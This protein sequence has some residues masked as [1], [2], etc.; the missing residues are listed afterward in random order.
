[1]KYRI[2]P[3]M[4]V[5]GVMAT[6]VLTGCGSNSDGSSSSA[7]PTSAASTTAGG[8]PTDPSAIL[9]ADNIK[10]V[11]ASY[12]GE[13]STLPASFGTPE[14]KP[15]KIGWVAALNANELNSQ[16]GY[17]IEKAVAA[18]GGELIALDANGDPAAQVTQIQKL[19]NQD[20]DGIIVWPLDATALVPALQQAKDAGI[21]ITAME[22]TPDGSVDLGP[23]DGQVIYG[24]DIDAYIAAK[25]MSEL[26]PGAQ[27]ASNRFAVP[28]PSI[29]YY[30]DRV[31][32]WAEQFG[33]KVVDTV[34]NPSDN[35]A[36]GEQMAGPIFAQYPDVKGWL[37][38]NDASA[39]GVTAASR[40][41]GLN[42]TAFGQ[43]GEDATIP[44]I[45][46]GQIALTVQP[47][48]DLWG[49]ELVNGILLVKAGQTIPKS[50][51]P[52][53]GNVI[54]KETVASAAPLK[55]IIDDAFAN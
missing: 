34:D 10:S 22:V 40:S 31:N 3:A 44:A 53:V 48:A 17:A 21:A 27:I 39:L 28:V 25:L 11:I 6:T 38:Y 45:E 24:R 23:V 19:I 8:D 4:I 46:S 13:N 14:V 15:L 36:G 47:P 18:I 5:L 12:T 9:G 49:R 7:A 37:A 43:N 29:N 54:T 26:Y 50:I 30:A 32:Y 52:G 55:N 16:V 1:M 41:A 2:M 20:V 33:L 42:V 35:V 51:F